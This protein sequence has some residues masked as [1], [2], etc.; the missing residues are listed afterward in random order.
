MFG[1]EDGSFDPT[2]GVVSTPQ[3]G[4]VFISVRTNTGNNMTSAQKT[5]LVNDLR[6][7]NVASITPVI[8]DP[9][10]TYL[11]LQTSFKFDSSK[12]TKEAT[13][14]ISNVTTTITD[15][16][17][18]KLTDFN[19]PFRHSELTRL[20]DTTDDSILSCTINNTLA[21]FVTP[22]LN[23]STSYNLY[24]NNKFY[25]PH[26][27]HNS[28]SGG[29]VATTGFKVSGDT[30]NA[31]YFDDDTGHIVIS[32]VEITSVENVDD[33]VSD[34]FR[35]TVIPNSKDIIPLR[36]QL[37]EIDLENSTFV[38]DVDT[39]AIGNTSG[40]TSYTT[41]SNLPDTKAY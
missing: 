36:N 1:G 25:N 8:V 32:P 30:T 19:K 38:A 28:S 21:K 20:V 10:I 18:D 4:K 37:L 23:V 12:T 35:L 26:S 41:T 16:N 5:N 14:L 29:I 22:T 39:L 34:K 17:T 7:Y 6:K 40:A 24:F 31:H 11:I 15:Y 2:L 3:Y 9:E 27:G 13:T 33:A